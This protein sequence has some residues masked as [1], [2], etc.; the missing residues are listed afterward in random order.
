MPRNDPDH[1]DAQGRRRKVVY[2]PALRALALIA[3]AVAAIASNNWWVLLGLVVLPILVWIAAGRNPLRL[4]RSLRRTWFFLAMLVVSFVLFPP[5]GEEVLVTIWGEQVNIAGLLF[6]VMMSLRILAIV[7]GSFVVRETGKPGELLTGLRQLGLPVAIGQTIEGTLV[8]LSGR[9]AQPRGERRGSGGRRDP[10]NSGKGAE[11]S[12]DEPER[13]LSRFRALLAARPRLISRLGSAFASSIQESA[14]TLHDLTTA[15]GQ[16]QVSMDAVVIT[17]LTVMAMSI[18]FMKIMPGIPILSGH[19]QLVIIPL[20]F[21][22]AD[23][24]KSRWAAT[25]MGVSLGVVAFMFGEGRFGL[26]EVAKYVA[27][28][29]TLDLLWPVL[30]RRRSAVLFGLAGT[31]MGVAWLAST[32]LAAAIVHAP[33]VFY[34]VILI[35]SVSQLAFSLFSGPVS[36]GLLRAIDGTG[37]EMRGAETGQPPADTEAMQAVRSDRKSGSRNGGGS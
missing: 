4:G 1:I 8:L 7:L 27:S 15:A 29:L 18:K 17:A 5:Q 30:R 37:I 31:L 14:T 9:D 26:L 34:T 11:P 13:R 10:P 12:E 2:G 36:L 3:L 20:Y 22:A 25:W 28:G 32:L 21:V 19:K 23:L 35:T 6:G 16:R 33:S 24:S